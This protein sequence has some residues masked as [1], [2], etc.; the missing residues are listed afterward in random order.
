MASTL[1]CMDQDGVAALFERY[2]HDTVS[3][4]ALEP[5]L[6]YWSHGDDACVAYCDTGGAWVAA[7]G[8]LCAE[9]E[10]DKTMAAFAEAAT[11]AG[12][13]VRF[14]AT[15]HDSEAFKSI[16]IGEQPEWDPSR[17]QEA[18]ASKRSLREQLRRARAKKVVI[19]NVSAGDIAGDDVELHQRVCGMVRD[20]QENQ[21]MAPMSF[22]VTLDLF[23]HKERKQYFVAERGDRIVGILVA[24]PIP[25]RNGWF[26]EDVLRAHDAPNGTVELLFHHAMEAAA[27][28]D[29]ELVSFGLAPLTG[30]VSSWL[31]RIRDHSEWLYDFHG[32]RAFK[33]KLQ[34]NTWRPI[35]L[36]L[37]QRERG[38]RA[39]VDSL[40]AFAG[41]SW[42]RFGMRTIVHAQPTLVW[43]LAILLIPWT[44]V[45]IQAPVALWFPS[46]S[47]KA[48]WIVFDMVLFAALID[49]ALDWKRGKA[50]ML[51]VASAA[52]SGV[53]LLQLFEF[54]YH[55]LQGPG[56]WALAMLAV[57]APLG[58]AVILALGAG[59]RERLYE[60]PTR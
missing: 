48:A 23:G 60:S 9:S 28:R 44:V 49:L 13:R 5:G 41:G 27:A 55:H 37:P 21:A 4:Q 15:E 12:K 20:W 18:L 22:L 7:G 2:G 52:D 17:W 45:L 16:C 32:L 57:L 51:A 31:L 14:F 19:R 40:T 38:I 36:T 29:I 42:I 1:V 53:G 47:I 10:R 43:W 50:Q 35:Y 8:P 56:Q 34:P 25:A 58:A 26:F 54:N 3:V 30:E 33:A 46:L 24:A 6:Q 59:M 39:T 11:A